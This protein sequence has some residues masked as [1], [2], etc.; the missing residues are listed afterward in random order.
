M[1]ELYLDDAEV[2]ITAYGVSGRIARS[3][4]QNLRREGLKVGLIRPKTVS[5]FPYESYEKLDFNRVKA[6]LDVEMS[7]PAQMVTDVELAVKGRCAIE[8]CLHSGGEIMGRAEIMDA[9]RKLCR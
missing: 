1:E 8:T 3:A 4:V 9:A 2:V 5:P 7:I 6:I